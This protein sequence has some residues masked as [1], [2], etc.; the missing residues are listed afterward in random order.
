MLLFI[1]F[2]LG[3]V[4]PRFSINGTSI[5]TARRFPLFFLVEMFMSASIAGESGG[6][7]LERA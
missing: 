1:S 6:L 5:A 2:E 7:R 3:D 4:A